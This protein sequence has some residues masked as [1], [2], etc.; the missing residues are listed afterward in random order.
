M[1]AAPILRPLSLGEVLDSAFTLYR[2]NFASFVAVALGPTL[3]MVAVAWLSGA[4]GVADPLNVDFG[5]IAMFLFVVVG[6]SLVMWG[7]LT[8]LASSAYGGVPASPG[9]ALS[10][11]LSRFFPLLGASILALVVIVVAFFA[12]AVVGG[13]VMAVA[14]PTMAISGA[15]GTV[16][17]VFL[18][19]AIFVAMVALYALAGAFFFAVFPAVVIEGKG[20]ASA[21]ARSIQ[22]ARG[23]LGRLVGLIIVCGF[24]VYLPVLG[25]M[26]LTGT[27]STVYDV[28][29]AQAAQGS[30]ALLLQQVLTWTSGALTTPFLVGALVVQYY[31]RRV[32][33]EALDV[34][35][36]ADRLAIA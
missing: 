31:D 8:H 20:P 32:R 22:L 4:S 33:T 19:I 21:I 27:F 29:A 36:A 26:V 13:V 5:A 18:I 12:V 14:I 2:R 24:I 17:G 1:S 15:A 23:A 30:T 25:V 10:V 16:V 28:N 35:A 9:A 11:A 6:A 3:A 7:A 34:Q